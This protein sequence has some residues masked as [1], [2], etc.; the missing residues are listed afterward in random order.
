[1]FK[2]FGHDLIA[3]I[4]SAS[5][6]RCLNHLK[7]RER[8]KPLSSRLGKTRYQKTLHERGSSLLKLKDSPAPAAS[9]FMHRW[10]SN[11]ANAVVISKPCEKCAL[12]KADATDGSA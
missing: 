11:K 3:R 2:Y 5:N 7:E 12:A 6:E 10:L 1:M 8:G 4:N 9:G